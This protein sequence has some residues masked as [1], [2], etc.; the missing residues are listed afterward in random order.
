MRK[1]AS[2]NT[3]APLNEPDFA[4]IVRAHRRGLHAAAM[5]AQV[6]SRQV[7]GY[8]DDPGCEPITEATTDLRAA[9]AKLPPEALTIP[10]PGKQSPWD[11]VLKF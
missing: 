10:T 7:L 2:D 1:G 11:F 8:L 6:F 9:L 4:W 5:A 3:V